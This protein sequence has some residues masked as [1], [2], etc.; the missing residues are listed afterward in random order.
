MPRSNSHPR[1]TA[2]AHAYPFASESAFRERVVALE[3]HA[4]GV[5]DGSPTSRL[6]ADLE[7]HQR[8]RGSGMS[9]E[10]L[11][12]IRDAAWF[13]DNARAQ[14]LGRHLCTLAKRYLESGG[15]RFRLRADGALPERGLSWR[16]LSF[17]L[18]TDLL[19]AAFAA[20]A[21]CEPPDDDILVVTP[22]L[23]EM[24][25][26][27]CA[28]THLHVGAGVPFG[29]LW[30]ARIRAVAHEPALLLKPDSGVPPFGDKL[31]F[32]AKLV[33]A[34]IVRLLLAAFL[35]HH[36][37]HSKNVDFRTYLQQ[38]LGGIAS[39]VAWGLGE[40]D[41]LHGLRL[42]L[43]Q[44]CGQTNTYSTE[45]TQRLYRGLIG[46]A[47]T[48]AGGASLGDVLAADPLAAWLPVAD[49][50]ALP[51]TRFAARAI[52]YLACHGEDSWFATLFWQYQRVRC[53]T[54]RYLVEEPG[55]A[56]LDW[57]TRHYLRIS[58]LRGALTELT[59]A[60]S[61]AVQSRDLALAALEARTSPESSWIEVRDELRTLARQAMA[62][63]PRAAQVRPEVGMVLHFIKEWDLVDSRRRRRHRHADPRQTAFSCRFGAWFQGRWRQAKAV[64]AALEHHP[65]LLL[66][67]RGADVANVELA[68]PTWALV[69]LFQI[70][71]EA[72]SWASARL[73]R[74]RPEWEVT[75]LRV[76]VHA[77]EDYRR[78]VEGLRRIHE[79]IA[80]GIVRMGDRIGHG[81]AL[82][83]DPVRW[84][85]ASRRVTQPREERLDDL[86][87]EFERYQ[88]GEI[89]A[90]ASRVEEVRAAAVRLGH[91]IHKELYSIDDLIEARRLRHDPDEL[92]WI[93]Y[94]FDRRRPT[95][96]VARELLYRY[97]TDPGVFERGQV[98]IEVDVSNHEV[99]VL[100]GLQ[101]W[102]CRELGRRE[103]TIE[104]NPSSNLV[105][106]DYL[107]L[108]EH[109]AFRLQPLLR[110][111][112]RP[113]VPVSV[114]TDN[115]ITFASSLADEFAYLYFA[116]LGRGV[117]ADD[118]L[119]WLARARENGY[120]SRFT[121]RA[122]SRPEV[123]QE[124]ARRLS[125]VVLK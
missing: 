34:A 110:D 25:R 103:I 52:R 22:R 39:R 108:G 75:P 98:P 21:N 5:L 46:A 83:E 24:L 116:M 19:V 33:A 101:A 105:I 1:L 3:R 109:A 92:A 93:G 67:L 49:G 111:P 57:F 63:R 74:V 66:V 94:P 14:S 32:Q 100:H 17:Y 82:G 2:E 85:E 47:P 12:Q 99:E 18:P 31:G 56:G 87:W 86:L 9:L 91:E 125:D 41:A 84:A 6:A 55:T 16:W 73:A 42:A 7:D 120:R 123:L 64:S 102:L 80:S 51:E 43:G 72:S 27:P 107:E 117:A 10:V 119:A 113:S 44:L 60:S 61:L 59:Y 4:V 106:A 115:P 58:P 11:R 37:G 70:V 96:G 81:V 77:G 62:H 97:L 15:R 13:P 8:A 65:E 38:Y 53:L 28:E 112:T 23:G 29:V 45:R 118:A 124:V 35:R 30:A 78:L 20:Q 36:E 69:P 71:R 79:P 54:Y 122:S 68:Q 95:S 89:Q 40:R 50:L 121:L 114:N 76:T 104:S 26:E 88:H 90:T 48:P